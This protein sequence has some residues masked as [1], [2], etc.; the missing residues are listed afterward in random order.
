MIR[1][2]YREALESQHKIL[3]VLWGVFIGGISLYL[4]IAKVFLA[5][6]QLA[7]AGSFSQTARFVLWLLALFDVATLMWWKKRFL[8]PEAILGGAKQYKILQ[9]LQ[10]H[11]TPL[12]ERAA[13][14]VSSYVT[15]KIVVFAMVEAVAIYGFAMV[16]TS[17]YFLG[18]YILSA[19]AAVLLLLEFPSR[20]FLME[21]LHEVEAGAESRPTEETDSAHASFHK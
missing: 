2:E 3:V 12:E 17:R 19:A 10:G 11:K 6:R 20:T 8:I 16:L 18:Q 4:W 14:A 7:M 1:A 15:S 9:V 13:Q 5:E 21:L